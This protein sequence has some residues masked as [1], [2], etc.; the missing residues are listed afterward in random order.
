MNCGKPIVMRNYPALAAIPTGLTVMMHNAQFIM[1]MSYILTILTI[2]ILT[3][4][5]DN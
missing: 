3:T 4:D 2:L 5:P 1:G